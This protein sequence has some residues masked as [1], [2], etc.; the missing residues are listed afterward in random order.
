MPQIILIALALTL[1]GCGVLIGN[2]KPSDYKSES[3]GIS[4][5]DR[6]EPGTWKKLD[7]QPAS[8]DADAS[9]SEIP[10]ASYQ[11]KSNSSI[12]SINSA[13][14][15]GR[16]KH[17][18]SLRD[19]T[20]QLLLGMTDLDLNQEKETS[21]QNVPALETTLRG[22]MNGESVM[23][24]S[25]VLQKKDCVYDLLYI[26]RPEQFPTHESDFAKFVSSLR[27]K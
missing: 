15:D 24:R 16:E 2:V 27:I 9:V 12:I 10:D 13:C 1:S 6:D 8:S 22:K 7:T 5:L 11:S 26:A 14:R 23:L 18:Q 20:R 21:L 4:Q 19:F 17:S 3:Y 25:M